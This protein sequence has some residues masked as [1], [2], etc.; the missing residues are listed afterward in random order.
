VAANT[1][2]GCPTVATEHVHVYVDDVLTASQDVNTIDGPSAFDIPVDLTAGQHVLRVDWESK[3][4]VLAS[5]S[6]NVSGPAPVPTGSAS[7][8]GTPPAGGS[9]START[10]APPTAATPIKRVL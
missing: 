6:V 8:S 7:I 4:T 9:A 2:N 3:G 5:R 1:A 10:P